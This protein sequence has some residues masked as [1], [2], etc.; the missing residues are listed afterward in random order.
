MK[1][2][3][4]REICVNGSDYAGAK[5]KID[6]YPIIVKVWRNGQEP[7][8][9]GDKVQILLR[10]ELP[11]VKQDLSGIRVDPELTYGARAS[12]MGCILIKT[13]GDPESDPTR[14]D[15]RYYES[16]YSGTTWREALTAGLDKL[17]NEF[18]KLRDEVAKRRLALEK[19]EG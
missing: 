14:G 6:R 11:G 9:Q 3:L 16:T 10:V 19:A 15:F 7:P 12:L 4:I 8:Q 17:W 2:G 5:I 18:D 13:W 1:E